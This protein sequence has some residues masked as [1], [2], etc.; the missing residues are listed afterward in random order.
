MEEISLKR[1]VA[2]EVRTALS[3]RKISGTKAAQDLGWSQAYLSRRLTGT[4]AFDLDDLEAIALYLGEPI[5][6]FFGMRDDY[7]RVLT[8][9][10]ARS[11]V[12]G[13][14]TASYST[15]TRPE[16]SEMSISSAYGPFS[17]AAA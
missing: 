7:P 6:R 10:P 9:V 11:S 13:S 16:I 17:E 1:Y 2:D 12:G 14:T 15:P 8:T 4:T 5:G 3:R